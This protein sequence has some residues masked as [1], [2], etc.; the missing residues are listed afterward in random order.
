MTKWEFVENELIAASIAGAFQRAK[1]YA[2]AMDYYNP[3]RN[4]LRERLSN[5]LRNLACKYAEP[6]SEDEHNSNIE[7]IADVLTHEFGT[8]GLLRDNQF[9]VGVAQK[10]LN[11]LLKYLWCL[12]KVP[13][14]PHCPFD[15][16]I[17]SQLDLNIEQKKRVQW[18]ELKCLGEYQL[19]VD[20]AKKKAE[21][22]NLSLSAWELKYWK[23]NRMSSRP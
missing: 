10:A 3:R 7:L 5:L 23:A 15:N 18:T 21:A 20:A 17:I 4:V 6:V 13:T 16:E 19:L 9:R 14:P 12:D 11:L 22:E 2:N 1:V 8:T